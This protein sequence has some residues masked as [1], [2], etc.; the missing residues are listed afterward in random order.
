MLIAPDGTV[1]GARLASSTANDQKLE[2]CI[3]DRARTWRFPRPKD[4]GL[5]LVTYPFI[6]KP[7]QGG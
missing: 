5:V 2:R 6:L 7:N 4:G 3:V 1:L